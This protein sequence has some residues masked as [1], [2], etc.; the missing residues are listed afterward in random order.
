MISRLPPRTPDLA[1]L[2]LDNLDAPQELVDLAITARARLEAGHFVE[3]FDKVEYVY[4]DK[5]P[6]IF[7]YNE[8]ACVMASE[9]LAQLWT[10][11]ENRLFRILLPEGA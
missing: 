7:D 3:V 4:P 11:A 6:F 1:G 2:D 8:H 5:A 10:Y 9:D